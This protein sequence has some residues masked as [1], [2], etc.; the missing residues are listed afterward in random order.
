LTRKVGGTGK[1]G[2]NAV[3]AGARD[4]GEDPGKEVS[5]YA[6]SVAEGHEAPCVRRTHLSNAPIGSILRGTRWEKEGTTHRFCTLAD[7][8]GSGKGAWVEVGGGEVVDVPT[9]EHPV[10]FGAKQEDGVYWW[11][12]A[13][14]RS[15]GQTR[16]PVEY[17]LRSGRTLGSAHSNAG[18]ANNGEPVKEILS[19][20]VG[21]GQLWD[22]WWGDL[23]LHYDLPLDGWGY[24]ISPKANGRQVR[25]V[26]DITPRRFKT[27]KSGPCCL[28]TNLNGRTT[29]F[30]MDQ[31]DMVQ[32]LRAKVAEWC[33][34]RPGEIR[35]QFC[36]KELEDGKV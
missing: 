5:I 10:L 13:F 24:F 19:N 22:C 26:L 15:P 11:W 1:G 8:A 29:R 4:N 31:G 27:V 2:D 34:V 6:V 3:R 25:P 28:Y 33:D 17:A 9:E 32:A 21:G 35:L 12:V 16:F 14:Y 7:T 18:W 30:L 36:A 20:I 23:R